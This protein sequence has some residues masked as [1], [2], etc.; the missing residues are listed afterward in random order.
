[1]LLK[2]FRLNAKGLTLIECIISIL[3][4]SIMLAGGLVIYP[5]A[6]TI[7]SLAMHKK[8]ALEIAVQ[9][10]EK[11]KNAGYADLL[12]PPPPPFDK[13]FGLVTT[14]PFTAQIHKTITDLP[15]APDMK[16]VE[17]EVSWTE[18][19]HD[20]SRNIKLETYMSKP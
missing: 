10:M 19:N 12:N 8:I 13:T 4:L 11:I 1:M 3:I 9:E 18:D 6:N 15:T 7:M 2:Y 16:K 5:N 14:Q 20:S 17:L